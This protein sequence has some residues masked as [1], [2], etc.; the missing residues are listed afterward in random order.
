MLVP[1]VAFS[2][3]ILAIH[4]LAALIGFGVVF[5]FP[6]LFASAAHLDPGVL[7]WL[8]R[9]RQRISRYLVNPGLLIVVLAGIYLASDEHQWKSFYVQWGIAAAIVIG[10][11]E[12]ALI[13]R[14]SGRLADLAERDL[15]ATGV[16]AGGQRVSAQWSDEYTRGQRLLTIGGTLIQIIVVITVFLMATHAGRS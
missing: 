10:G 5:A 6:I 1:A 16:P 2:D 15:A 3:F 9:A 13:T 11:I 7:P 4:I 14:R 12:G 8:L